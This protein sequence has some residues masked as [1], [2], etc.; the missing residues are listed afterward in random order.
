MPTMATFLQLLIL[1]A[2]Y[3]G[4]KGQAEDIDRT[5]L[6]CDREVKE[7][8]NSLAAA[9]CPATFA[10]VSHTRPV[11]D[12]VPTQTQTHRSHSI[13]ISRWFL[14][15][16]HADHTRS[17]C[18]SVLP[19][20]RTKEGDHCVS[21]TLVTVH[22][23]C[24]RLGLF[25]NHT[26][27]DRSCSYW[28]WGIAIF[29][30]PIHRPWCGELCQFRTIQLVCFPRVQPFHLLY[31][32]WLVVRLQLSHLDSTS[33]SFVKHNLRTNIFLISRTSCVERV[34]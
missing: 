18:A 15:R 33:V 34:S 26:L 29:G 12:P 31:W 9:L 1:T 6:W 7:G 4:R 25:G 10:I 19:K 24:R 22:S 20:P 11:P 17:R 21:I 13:T 28:S 14:K 2:D 5:P 8:S 27:L 16:K 32:S 30:N 3:S 23:L